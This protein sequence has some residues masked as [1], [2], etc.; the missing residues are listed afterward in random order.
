M[1]ITVEQLDSGETLRKVELPFYT[2]RDNFGWDLDAS[3]YTC[4][5]SMCWMLACFAKPSLSEAH[6]PNGDF[7][8]YYRELVA[9]YGDTTDHGNQTAALDYLGIKTEWRTDM[10]LAEVASAIEATGRPVGL[11]IMHN[12]SLDYQDTD[13]LTGGHMIVAHGTFR[14]ASGQLTALLISDPNGDLDLQNGGYPN[15]AANG[16]QLRYSYY[17]L[18][19]RFETDSNGYFTPGPCGWARLSSVAS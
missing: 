8:Y 15:K 7:S 1:G 12:S 6:G 2:Q 3:G 18:Q 10:T 5:S 16:K 13:G 9:P 19:R 4:N 14:S 11:G 17:R